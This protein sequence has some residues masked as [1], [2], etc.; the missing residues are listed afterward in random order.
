M[1]DYFAL[2]LTHGLM[3]LV[4]WRLLFRPDVDDASAV[5]REDGHDGHA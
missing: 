5:K 3:F 2:A 1:I 4:A